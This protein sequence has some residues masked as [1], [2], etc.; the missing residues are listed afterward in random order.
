M[1]TTDLDTGDPDATQLVTE[2]A[3]RKRHHQ[4]IDGAPQIAVKEVMAQLEIKEKRLTEHLDCSAQNAVNGPVAGLPVELH[5]MMTTW[6]S[7][8]GVFEAP[9][10]AKNGLTAWKGRPNYA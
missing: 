7:I 4:R 1:A 6:E 5:A 2:S 3:C 8:S 10:S 9:H